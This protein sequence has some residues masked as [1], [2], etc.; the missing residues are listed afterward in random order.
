MKLIVDQV[1]TLVPNVPL[2]DPTGELAEGQLYLPPSPSPGTAWYA[3]GPVKPFAIPLP[4]TTNGAN[5]EVIDVSFRLQVAD[6]ETGPSGGRLL[7]C[8]PEGY[9]FKFSSQ[10]TS[11]ATSGWLTLSFDGPLNAQNV[12]FVKNREAFAP[13]GFQGNV[14]WQ[15]VDPKNTVLAQT[16]TPLEFYILHPNLPPYFTASDGTLNPIPIKLLRIFLGQSMQRGIQTRTAWLK[17]VTSIIHGSID[18]NT[19]NEKMT[20]HHFFKYEVWVGGP[21]YTW[22]DGGSFKLEKWLQF[23]KE[24]ETALA[25]SSTDTSATL[26]Q[27]LH[28]VNCFDQ[29]GIAWIALSLGMDHNTLAWEHKQVY[30]YLRSCQL[31]GWGECNN[32]FFAGDKDQRLLQNPFDRRRQAF[33]NHVFLSFGDNPV[34]GQASVTRNTTNKRI[35]PPDMS[36]FIIDACAGPFVG[37]QTYTAYVQ[38]AIDDKGLQAG[39]QEQ[40]HSNPRFPWVENNYTLLSGIVALDQKTTG[41]SLWTEYDTQYGIADAT[42]QPFNPSFPD[43][44]TVLEIDLH[45]TCSH[46][47]KFVKPR[48]PFYVGWNDATNPSFSKQ[49]T[50]D[51][52]DQAGDVG[53]FYR[54]KEN[55][56][57]NE[58]DKSFYYVKISILRSRDDALSNMKGRMSLFSP[59]GGAAF[60][61]AVDGAGSLHF[62]LACSKSIELFMYQNMVFEL[63]GFVDSQMSDTDWKSASTVNQ[64]SILYQAAVDLAKYVATKATPMNLTLG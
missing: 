18:P 43:P 44:P 1:G 56:M 4:G 39:L 33:R 52:G 57:E 12:L 37:N 38:K 47:D 8:F 42:Q 31:V 54:L 46:V 60:T 24:G 30:G 61:R 2:S 55:W 5:I 51:T 59:P 62:Q 19:G 25:S 21:A 36:R 64:K 16:S 6:G 32:P 50:Q 49:Q 35:T 22:E 23:W 29:A 10:D 40:N 17:W 58:W 13:I 7:G 45:D 20:S 63:G 34:N 48:C 11:G 27:N 15:Y 26:S 9:N 14:V 28:T 41:S 3:G 53:C